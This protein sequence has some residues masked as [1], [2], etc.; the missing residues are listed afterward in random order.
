M[1]AFRE[2]AIPSPARENKGAERKAHQI[3]LR[4]R[5]TAFKAAGLDINNKAHSEELLDLL[6][7][8]VYG[9]R[10]KGAPRKWTPKRLRH[11]LNS[12]NE[13][14]AADPKLKEWP[15]CKLLSQG[16]GGQGRYKGL[17]SMTLRRLL[18]TAKALDQFAGSVPEV[19][20][21][22]TAGPADRPK[23]S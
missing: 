2:P 8:A 12:V 14:R 15:C 10:W 7:W 19:L 22:E 1:K 17:N 4:A 13:L 3:F 5:Q 11:L 18:Q 16:K 6:A 23:T 9:G 20:G 21:L